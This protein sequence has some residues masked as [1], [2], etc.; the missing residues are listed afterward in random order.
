MAHGLSTTRA[1]QIFQVFRLGAV[2]LTSV[3]FAKSGL[4]TA[5]IGA[6]EMLLYIGVLFTFLWVNG[7][8]QG[9]T[10]VYAQLDESGRKSFIFNNFLVFCGLFL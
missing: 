10:P 8:L 2:V 9:M 7:L 6:Y 4:S 3:L 5:D 1:L